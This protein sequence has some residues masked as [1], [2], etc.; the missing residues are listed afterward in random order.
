MSGNGCGTQ[1]GYARHRRKGEEAC[2][3]CKEANR[4]G[5]KEWSERSFNRERRRRQARARS[6]AKNRLAALHSEDY[7][8][9]YAAAL[10]EVGG[11][12]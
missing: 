6:M 2:E 8:S 9:L 3:P 10:R 1:A 7:E 5:V 11:S 4:A 12:R